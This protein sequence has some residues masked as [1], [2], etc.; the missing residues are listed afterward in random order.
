MGFLDGLFNNHEKAI[1]IM[2]DNISTIG[3]K[4]HQISQSVIKTYSNSTHPLDKLACG[5]AYINEGAAYRKLAI[6]CFEYYFSHP[7]KMPI[8]ENKHPYFSEWQL[9]SEL[10][11]LYE[12]EYDFDKA[13]HELEECIRF[14]SIN[15][16]VE[17]TR[18]AD[19]IVKKE[20]VDQA[21]E[22]IIQIKKSN[23]YP[24][25][26][27]MIDYEYNELLK[28]KDKGYVY[29]PRKRKT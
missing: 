7:S 11:N 9:H 28:K 22:Y 1:R 24:K 23:I 10:A 6:E 17:Y 20:G 12:K 14:S 8:A 19:V 16:G 27:N 5:L 21:I 13:I 2:Y 18:I 15:D 3:A 25:M 26:K 29:R 4:R